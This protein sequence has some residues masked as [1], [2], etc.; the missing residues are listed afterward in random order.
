MY[1]FHVFLTGAFGRLGAH[2]LARLAD[3]GCRITAFDRKTAKTRASRN[4]L[5]KGHRF[6]TSWGD[7]RD[8]ESL[9]RIIA[10]AKPDAIIHLAEVSPLGLRDPQRARG[11]NV[12]GTRALLRAA[13]SL[14]KRPH[15][16]LASS[17]HVHGP[18]NGSKPLPLLTADTPPAPADTYGRHKVLCEESLRASALPFTILR[19]GEV[20]HLDPADPPS[21]ASVRMSFELPRRPHPSVDP[22]DAALA[23]A[24]AATIPGAAAAP[25][26][27]AVGRTGGS[28]TET[29]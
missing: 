2:T 24:G 27:S 26:R 13:A 23:F 8:A 6:E 20:L 15:F 1:S 28:V 16:I 14:P 3:R 18:R 29:S 17:T 7:L 25:S 11:V 12:E 10:K 19:L 5:R 22:R 9:H 21:E 4:E